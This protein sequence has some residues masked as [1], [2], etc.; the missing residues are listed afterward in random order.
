M[1][2]LG[3]A[4]CIGAL[5]EN[6]FLLKFVCLF[7]I[8]MFSSILCCAYIILYYAYIMSM[9]V[10]NFRAAYVTGCGLV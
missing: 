8:I 1:F 2:V 9:S 10:Q 6:S 7:K 5:R 3:F 4:G